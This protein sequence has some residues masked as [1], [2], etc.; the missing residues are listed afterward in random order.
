[1]VLNST[2]NNI[3]AISWRAVLLVEKTGVSGE[4]RPAIM[5]SKSNKIIVEA[6]EFDTPETYMYNRTFNRMLSS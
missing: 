2:V 1:M 5:V 6:V 4:N 3:S